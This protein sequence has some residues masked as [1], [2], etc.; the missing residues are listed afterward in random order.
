MASEA[1]VLDGMRDLL[2]AL[3]DGLVTMHLVMIQMSGCRMQDPIGSISMSMLMICLF[4]V[5]IQW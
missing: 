2:I 1:L 3:W 5:R 4:I